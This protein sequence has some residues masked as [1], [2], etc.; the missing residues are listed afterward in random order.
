[1]TYLRTKAEP[2]RPTQD[3][4]RKAISRE[5]PLPPEEQRDILQCL[6]P[7]RPM[8]YGDIE[9]RAKMLGLHLPGHTNVGKYLMFLS[10]RGLLGREKCRRSDQ[11]IFTY[12]GNV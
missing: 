9:T 5:V 8:T 3:T 4:L 11:M 2:N 6:R 10:R 7:G 12:L 1:M